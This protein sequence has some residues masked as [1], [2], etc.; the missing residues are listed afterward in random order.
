M[1]LALM[2]KTLLIS[3]MLMLLGIG[4]MTAQENMTFEQIEAKANQGDLKYMYALAKI[5]KS[6]KM[7]IAENE[8]LA[9]KW[10]RASLDKAKKVAGRGNVE[11][12]NI[13]LTIYMKDPC[14]VVGSRCGPEFYQ[15][16]DKAVEDD[17]F[18]AQLMK[19]K[20]SANN[21]QWK[22]VVYVTKKLIANPEN[23]KKDGA[24]FLGYCYYY[25]LGG[26]QRDYKQA[27]KYFKMQ[28]DSKG[29]TSE[30]L[31]RVGMGLCYYHG[32]GTKKNMAKA[33]QCWKESEYALDAETTYLYASCL[34]N[35]TGTAKDVETGCDLLKR[36]GHR[37]GITSDIQQKADALLT[38]V[39]DEASRQEFLAEQERRER[40]QKREQKRRAEEERQNLIYEGQYTNTGHAYSSDGSFQNLGNAHL[41]NV[42]I[43][44]NILYVEGEGI[45]RS[46]SDGDWIF[47]TS[48]G[49]TVFLYNTKTTEIRRR[50]I[51]QMA[52]MGVVNTSFSDVVCVR[53]NQLA[54]FSAPPGNYQS[55]SYSRST[56][57]TGNKHVCRACDGRGW[58]P[59]EEGVASYGN[60]KWCRECKR[61]VSRSHWHKT[62][63]SCKGHGQW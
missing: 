43:C 55:D 44:K 37:D 36:I 41:F 34:I 2:K 1:I 29:S 20:E 30:N 62:C 19:A 25:G 22:D 21:K 61:V 17:I 5:Y 16:L 60:D 27:F 24:G 3:F 28:L 38:Y 26:L 7:G 52:I 40:E 56:T 9:R 53:G 14:G 46:S 51:M 18:E 4:T 45:P 10:Y 8:T 35:G 13:I 32:R 54:A 49:Q 58:V 63:E 6:G 33:V 50:E 31:A 59:T 23:K 12:Y 57:T 15:W 11:A 39:E 47:Y 48:N 42:K